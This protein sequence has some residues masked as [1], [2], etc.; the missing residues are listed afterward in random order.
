MSKDK[1]KMN[2][3]IAKYN[4]IFKKPLELVT[5]FVNKD[6]VLQKRVIRLLENSIS[7]KKEIS[8]KDIEK[9]YPTTKGFII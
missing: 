4:E 1:F 2:D 8:K 3:L 6:M 7:S 5:I 9:F